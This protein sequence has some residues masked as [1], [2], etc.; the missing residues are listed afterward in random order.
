MQGNSLGGSPTVSSGSGQSGTAHTETGQASITKPSAAGHSTPIKGHVLPQQNAEAGVREQWRV[1]AFTYNH[2]DQAQKKADTIMQAHADLR[3]E[4]FN[5]TGRAPYLVTVGGVMSRE[6]AFAFVQQVRRL[7]LPRDTYA[8]NY[9][10][11][12]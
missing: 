2:V 9:N 10:G 4:V 5:P 8:Q 1:I 7:G 11:K 12:H 3:P 6:Q